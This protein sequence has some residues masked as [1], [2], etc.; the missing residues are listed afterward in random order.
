[1]EIDYLK[2]KAN[3]VRGAWF[4]EMLCH[5]FPIKYPVLNKPVKQWLRMKN[6]RPERGSTEGSKYVELARKLRITMKQNNEIKSLAELDNVIWQI[7][8]DYNK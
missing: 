7:V 1:M 6:W 3:P 5:F 4:S 2:K 8:D